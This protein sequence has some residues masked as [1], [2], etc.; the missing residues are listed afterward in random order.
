MNLILPINE[1]PIITSWQWHAALFSILQ[2]D[3]KAIQWI[4]SNYIQLRLVID[5]KKKLHFLDFL[6]GDTTLSKCPY[7]FFQP[8]IDE[9]IK[10]CCQSIIDFI[11]K[12]LD[13]GL[14]VFGIFDQGKLI[15]KNHK[16]PHEVFI[17]GYD[18]E[19]KYFYTKDFIFNNGKYTGKRISY[20]DI[21]Y[22]Y[23]NITNEDFKF[24][25]LLNNYKRGLF[26]IGKNTDRLYYQLDINWLKVLLSDYLDSSNTH[27]RS[28]ICWQKRD[29]NDYIYG[30][31][32]YD[33]LCEFLENH[34][35]TLV[36]DI[37]PLH[38]LYDHKLLMRSRINYLHDKGYIGSQFMGGLRILEQES[39][40]IRNLYLKMSIKGN[41]SAFKELNKKLLVLRNLEC[42][43]YSELLTEL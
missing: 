2:D 10:M 1:K 12:S 32:I 28:K 22:A 27:N 13:M 14:Y 8:V 36:D 25:N 17:Y 3:E 43:I 40:N 7:I 21:E 35:R 23:Q 39:L 26:L 11:K 16:F 6:P 5:R 20:S 34:E 19:N 33:R 15:G 9:Q 42:E 38:V 29:E 30:I 24:R 37:R 18:D 41:R 4:Y 31:K